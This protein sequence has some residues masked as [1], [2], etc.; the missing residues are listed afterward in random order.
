MRKISGC[1][2]N[3]FEVIL[4]LRECRGEKGGRHEAFET[5]PAHR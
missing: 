2:K 4:K 1:C 5:L 3:Q